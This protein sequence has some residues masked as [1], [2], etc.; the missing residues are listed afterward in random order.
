VKAIVES[1]AWWT[2]IMGMSVG[3]LIGLFVVVQTAWKEGR[4]WHVWPAFAGS[5]CLLAAYLAAWTCYFYQQKYGF[6]FND[7]T[8]RM[9]FVRP[10]SL[11]SA[12]A[13][14]LAL[15]N[16]GKQRSAL[17]IGAVLVQMYCIFQIDEI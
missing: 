2:L 16:K 12:A 1:I 3:P 10:M 8:I 13:L 15:F 11:L 4:S 7:P 17:L 6:D 5:L 14:V 9:R